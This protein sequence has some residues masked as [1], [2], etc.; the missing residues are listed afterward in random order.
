MSK[1]AEDIAVEHPYQ[2][3]I[4]L[5][6]GAVDDLCPGT[7]HG[8]GNHLDAIASLIRDELAANLA[9]GERIVKCLV[10]KKR[11]GGG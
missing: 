1:E 7:W 10:G 11:R 3:E 5:V 6:F 9:G 4:I 2:L 8:R